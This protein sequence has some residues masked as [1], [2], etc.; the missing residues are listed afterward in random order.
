MSNSDGK[1]SLTLVEEITHRVVNEYS[2]AI[3]AISR[4]AAQSTDPG[5]RLVLT[6][7]VKQLHSF[8]N[9][10]RALQAPQT[11]GFAD[12]GD[13]LEQL[14]S[15]LSAADLQARRV[16]LI[17]FLDSVTLEV[18]RCWRVGWILAELINNAVKHGFN[19]GG[20]VIVVEVMNVD[21]DVRCQVVDNGGALPD[22]TPS[23]GQHVIRA[24][25]AEL[26][27]GVQ[28]RFAADGV[29]ALLRFPIVAPSPAGD[30]LA[31][32][33]PAIDCIDV[34]IERGPSAA[35]RGRRP[36]GE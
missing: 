30:A 23:H 20:G 6:K 32:D 10:H 28:W 17:L 18:E 22:P 16:R 3:A 25:A 33:D 31:R 7:A 13:Y 15:A 27:G 26:A 34:E 35:P 14:C 1:Y 19:G 12:L 11:G 9:V 8:A 24:L 36:E 5:V 21:G 4:S 29:T 2:Q